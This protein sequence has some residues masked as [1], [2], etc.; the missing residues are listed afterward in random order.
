MKERHF[1]DS[2]SAY[3]RAGRGGD[4]SASFRREAH[5]EFGGP[6]GGDGGRGGDVVLVGSRHEDSLESI[7]YNPRLV[8]G[9][10]GPGRG[11][12]MHGRNGRDLEVPVP[13][14]TV[15]TDEATGEV[16]FDIVEDGQ[17]AIIAKGGRGGWG[18]V[19]FKSATNQAPTRFIP[20][21][22]GEEFRYR[23]EL[24][25]I[26]E[27]GLVGFPNAGKSSLLTA[28]SGARPKVGAYPFTTLNPIIGT[29]VFKDGA[30]LR[31]ADIPG[32]I[33]GAH[34]GVGLGS[35]FLKHISRATVLAYVIDCAGVD[36]RDPAADWRALRSEIRL[37]DKEMAKRPTLLIANKMD[38]PGAEE[39]R[40]KL[41]KAA[42]RKAVAVSA[43]NGD[44]IEALLAR[45]RTARG[46][47]PRTSTGSGLRGGDAADLQ[48]SDGAAGKV[49]GATPRTSTGDDGHQE[50]SAE[51]LARASFL[52]P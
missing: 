36:G 24:K 27:I 3:V 50:V 4:G 47:T 11:Q 18:N 35:D 23:F 21:A 39:G 8:A 45:M 22:D 42:R 6:D 20:G 38:L 9:N 26:A 37:Y 14:G 30:T 2:V 7:F 51:K 15:V 43:A 48:N 31:V 12:Q 29:V 1:I 17:R 49:R 52:S 5:V 19:H 16:V 10:G 40:A 13:C 44:G 41:E 25:V 33:G 34:E 46:A 32:I 28:I